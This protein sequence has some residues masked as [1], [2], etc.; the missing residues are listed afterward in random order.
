[1]PSGFTVVDLKPA[2][3]KLSVRIVPLTPEGEPSPAV[4]PPKAA[5]G[6]GVSAA[7]R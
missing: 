3:V 4:E 1:V 7:R 2:R 6:N 5:A